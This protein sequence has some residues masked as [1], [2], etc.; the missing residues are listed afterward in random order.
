MATKEQAFAGQLRGHRAT[1][2]LS[3]AELGSLIGVTGSAIGNWERGEDEPNRDNVYALE[4]ALGLDSGELSRLLGYA[5]ADAAPS[6][7]DLL[8]GLFEEVRELRSEVRELR[9]EVRGPRERG[10]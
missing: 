3:Q 6:L 1:A 9:A 4:R 5:P 7:Q 10:S 2:G 8:S